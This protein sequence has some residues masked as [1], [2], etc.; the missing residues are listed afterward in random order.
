MLCV[1]VVNVRVR[2]FDHLNLMSM[3]CPVVCVDYP[4][5]GAVRRAGRSDAETGQSL[6]AS[7]VSLCASLAKEIG[8]FV[9]IDFTRHGVRVFS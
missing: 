5:D 1:D 8:L 2:G 3:I 9:E 4:V 7:V 6:G